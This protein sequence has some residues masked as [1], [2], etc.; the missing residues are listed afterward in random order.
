M[1]PRLAS[2]LLCST[3]GLWISD[4]PAF[5]FQMLELQ[6]CTTK[7]GLYSAVHGPQGSVSARQALYQQS[8]SILGKATCLTCTALNSLESTYK[9]LC[10][11][12]VIYDSKV[13][14]G[15]QKAN[16]QEPPPLCRH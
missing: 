3:G 5:T 12:K 1:Y 2:N 7:P 11:P 14:W 10:G 8:L 15:L 9:E 16:P 4:L 13:L 6:A